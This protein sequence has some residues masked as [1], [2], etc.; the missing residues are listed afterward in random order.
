M[1][2][3]F[4]QSW[5][6]SNY[7]YIR[8]TLAGIFANDIALPREA[9]QDM[10]DRSLVHPEWREAFRDEL[11]KAVVD[12][13]TPWLELFANENYEVGDASSNEDAKNQILTLLWQKVCPDEPVPN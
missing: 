1:K 9:Q 6:M 12:R 2:I 11:R 7:F 8:K 4:P 5:Q 3:D 13:T 10:L